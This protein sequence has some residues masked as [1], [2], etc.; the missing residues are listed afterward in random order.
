MEFVEDAGE[1]NL[2]G[3][4]TAISSSKVRPP[5]MV[6]V[7][8]D[9]AVYESSEGMLQVITTDALI[10]GYH[11]DYAFYTMEQVGNKAMVV[12]L[13]DIAAMN[14]RPILATVALGIP[15]SYPLEN[16][17]ALY[18]GLTHAA[19]TY[20]VQIVGG[21]TTRSPV[22]MLSITVIG[23]VA[24]SCIVY[25][26]GAKLG[27]YICV[28]GIVG[29]A[30]MGLDLLRNDA[31]PS[32]IGQ[33]IWDQ[34]TS[35]H[36]M[37]VPRLDLVDQWASQGVHPSAMIDISDGLAN[38]IHHICKASDCGAVLWESC[39]PLPEECPTGLDPPR[40]SLDYGLNGGDDYE[41][42]FT[43][44][45]DVLNQM[46]LDQITIIGEITEQ[47]VRL[48]R[49]SGTIESLPAKGHD[50]FTSADPQDTNPEDS[51]Q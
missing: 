35:R 27:D 16:L 1:F 36:L 17:D 8:D 49:I 3:R 12:N 33:N 30:A 48:H 47:D 14:A 29:E 20:G 38:E 51:E 2:I 18:H 37:P 25:R 42:L 24:Q 4:L 10:E 45:A 13:S 6:G 34:L 26:D 7:G 44:S 19:S 50:H 39:L 23:E 40:S 15:S 21:D 28:S 43:A 5:V 11:F 41:L 32:I 31:D 9:A 22:L 46:S